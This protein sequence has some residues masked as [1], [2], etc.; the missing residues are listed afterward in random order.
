[1]CPPL[2]TVLKASVG[3]LAGLPTAEM[4]EVL[5]IFLSSTLTCT[6]SF[7]SSYENNYGMIRYYFICH[8]T[9]WILKGQGHEIFHPTFFSDEMLNHCRIWL[10]FRGGTGT[11]RIER[12]IFFFP[13]FLTP[14]SQIFSI[15]LPILKVNFCSSCIAVLPKHILFVTI[16]A[17]RGHDIERR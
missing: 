1:M 2:L 7:C 17:I 14:E 12:Y 15:S 4:V 10:R 11:I 6:V 5:E 16:K 13:L 8:Y 3:K 9:E